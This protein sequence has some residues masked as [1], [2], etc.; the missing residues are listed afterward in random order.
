MKN[1]FGLIA[2]LG[3]ASTTVAQVNSEGQAAT[4]WFYRPA[5]SP[6]PQE[7]PTVH[8]VGGLTR[9]LGKIAP[10]EFFGYPVST[11][12]HVFSYTGA[13]ARGQSL[14]L[15]LKSG[16]QIFVE[17]QFRGFKRV[18]SIDGIEAI[19]KA[20]PVP[21][22]RV[23]DKV[24]LR[25]FEPVSITSMTPVKTTAVAKPITM[26]PP[27][28]PLTFVPL[29]SNTGGATTV[30]AEPARSTPPASRTA[31]VT[32]S[33]PA[34]SAGHANS[35]VPGDAALNLNISMTPGP[36]SLGSPFVAPVVS[37]AAASKP[38]APPV[39]STSAGRSNVA[40]RPASATV[41]PTVTAPVTR[42]AASSVPPP[43]SAPAAST[44][45]TSQVTAT[46][47]SASTSS[48]TTPAVV[49]PAPV[50]TAAPV[51]SPTPSV[52][53]APAPAVKETSSAS[54]A[55]PMVA[56]R[57]EP[58][59]V[60]RV[61][62]PR[63]AWPEQPATFYE[64]FQK[65]TLQAVEKKQYVEAVVAFDRN[66]FWVI[67]G[68]GNTVKAFA[69]TDIRSAEYAYSRSAQWKAIA[70]G[71]PTSSSAGGNRHWFM[72][73]TQDDYVLLQL[74]KENY[75]SAVRAFEIRTGQKVETE[76]GEIN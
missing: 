6:A 37:V 70:S 66:Y 58:A 52:P 53:P 46:A 5:D 20:Q 3:L 21:E 4:V 71:A 39:V 10:G 62:Q 35:T 32:V 36:V 75:R 16:E 48:R 55:Q 74:D 57:N 9:Q 1:L 41:T 19:G 12:T 7:L 34:A 28:A 59:P 73:Q 61:N 29:P 65:A 17:V 49:T 11:G 40:S 47:A 56:S 24:V 23:L 64:V 76:T 63:P 13:P 54:S 50:A 67:D 18:P 27:G 31:P 14:N 26:P 30:V 25:K 60:A 72:V 38:S 43:A 42:P 69:Y 68:R 33:A 45:T 8:K 44:R 2:M 22:K 15:E 51:A